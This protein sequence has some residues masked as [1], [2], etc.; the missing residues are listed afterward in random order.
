MGFVD[1]QEHKTPP[2]VEVREGGAKLGE[3]TDEAKG[4]F[5]LESEQGLMVESGGRQV[6]IGEVDDGVD[7]RVE[8]VGKGA[9]S[10]GLASADIAGDEGREVLL[11]GE[12]EAALDFAVATRRVKVL[13]GDGPGERGGAE[14]VE[15]IESSHRF[16]SPLD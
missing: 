1:D 3:E 7:I 16:H 2:A 4:R 15:I 8:G 6:R 14:A 9:E 5:G 10:G 12:G 11:E 13:A